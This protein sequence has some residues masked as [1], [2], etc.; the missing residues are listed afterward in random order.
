MRSLDRGPDRKCVLR[1]DG[2]A[3]LY[4][5]LILA[6]GTRRYIAP[7][8]GLEREGGGKPGIFGFRSLE[9]C[10]RIAEYS[11]AG[12]QEITLGMRPSK[13]LFETPC[14]I[15]DQVVLGPSSRL[16]VATNHSRF[17]NYRC[18]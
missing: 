12:E 15:V 10:R 17:T 4:D 14:E 6:M 1:D 11:G 18:G 8:E 16:A 13:I 9:D 5:K 7:I 3:E 2:T